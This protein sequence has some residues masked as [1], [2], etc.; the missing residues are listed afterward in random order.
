MAPGGANAALRFGYSFIPVGYFFAG[1]RPCGATE[2][3]PARFHVSRST[4][5]GSSQGPLIPFRSRE[6]PG[7]PGAEQ[8]SRPLPAGGGGLQLYALVPSARLIASRP[9]TSVPLVGF[10]VLR[11]NGAGESCDLGPECRRQCVEERAHFGAGERSRRPRRDLSLALPTCSYA[12][13]LGKSGASTRG[14]P[15]TYFW[16]EEERR[17]RGGC[18]ASRNRVFSRSS[19][20]GPS[21]ASIT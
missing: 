17:G 10:V 18:T 14:R 19:I 5:P 15:A 1:Y 16:N 6:N 11:S 2:L 8:T 21:G 4:R 7:A 12:A 3:S 20:S 9:S 13:H